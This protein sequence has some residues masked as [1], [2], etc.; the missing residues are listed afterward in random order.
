MQQIFVVIFMSINVDD[1]I[2]TQFLLLIQWW[3]KLNKLKISLCNEPYTRTVTCIW[4]L[5]ASIRA[6]T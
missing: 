6:K 3:G 5:V 4:T 2:L 1:F